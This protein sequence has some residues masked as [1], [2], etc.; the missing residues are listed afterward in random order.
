MR[1]RD[2]FLLSLVCCAVPGRLPAQAVNARLQAYSLDFDTP[3]EGT[4][5]V[6]VEA[7]DARLRA[8]HGIALPTTAVG[9]LDLRNLRLALVRPDANEY[10]ASVPKIGILFAWFQLH[11]EAAT[12]LDGATR[13][14]F[15]LMIKQS[16]N[17]LAAKYSELLGLKPIQSA[18]NAAGF[19][20]LKHGGGLWVGKHY[21]KNTE[22]YVDPVGGHSHSATVRQVM[23]FYLQLEQGRLISPAASKTMREIFASPDIPHRDD[24]FVL[25]LAGRGLEI[26]RKSGWW[27]TWFHDSAVIVGPGR[28]YLIVA[29][30]HHA[31]GDD[32]LA[33]LAPAIDD[34]LAPGRR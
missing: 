30:T 25:G 24:K 28:H 7:I 33:D 26:R 11:P 9:V 17:E 4:L 31:K 5:Q 34:L 19:Y 12:N 23:R 6:E 2:V 14:E 18:L 20:D 16:D 27:Q 21:G 1:W 29:L 13:R 32:Y 15:G 22:R 3:V 10:A 8:K